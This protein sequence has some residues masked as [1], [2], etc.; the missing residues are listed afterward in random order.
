MRLR[1]LI[2]LI[3]LTLSLSGGGGALAAGASAAPQVSF[4]SIVGQFMCTTCHE[5][6]NQVNSPQ[7]ISEK[8]TLQGLIARRLTVGEIKS[9]MVD[10][11]GPQVLA[12][13]QADGFNLTIYILPPAIFV[14]GVGACSSTRCPNGVLALGRRS[15]WR[16][17]RRCRPRTPG[18]SMTS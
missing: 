13:P 1:R 5:P 11:Y 16:M 4:Y 2:A 10:Q 18:G 8:Q 15:R 3:A 12:R 14:G 9:V 7:A 6:L 17:P